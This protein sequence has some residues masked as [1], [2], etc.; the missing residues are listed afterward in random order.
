MIGL[1][2]SKGA[3]QETTA[4]SFP[5]DAVTSVGASG[6]PAGVMGVEAPEARLHPTPFMAFA[7][8]VYARPFVRPVTVHVRGPDDQEHVFP[9]GDEVTA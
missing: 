1:P 8:N 6:G 2:P 7:V 5:P 3:V 9:S 4:S